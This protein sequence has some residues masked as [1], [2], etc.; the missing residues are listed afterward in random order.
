MLPHT[1]TFG[2]AQDIDL[3]GEQK[4]FDDFTIALLVYAGNT[5]G[6]VLCCHMADL[7]S[8]FIVAYKASTVAFAWVPV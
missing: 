3:S 1:N 5:N 2:M 6:G 4:I 7:C 8:P